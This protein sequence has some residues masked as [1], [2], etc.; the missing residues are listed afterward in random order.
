MRNATRP[1]QRS[2]RMLRSGFLVAAHRTPVDI[3]SLFRDMRSNDDLAMYRT[4]RQVL[5]GEYDWLEEGIVGLQEI[6][7]PG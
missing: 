1:Y 3:D 4:A 6:G 5:D 7:L 2:R